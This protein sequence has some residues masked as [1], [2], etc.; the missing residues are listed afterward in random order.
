M[1]R[2]I[3]WGFIGTVDFGRHSLC[4]LWRGGSFRWQQNVAAAHWP[5]PA[6]RSLLLRVPVQYPRGFHSPGP[7]FHTG[8]TDMR[9]GCEPKGTVAG[10]R[11]WF[12]LLYP[13]ASG[14]E[15]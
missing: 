3:L 2:P 13:T 12:S 6:E 9:V 1:V 7:C 4:Q 15:P 8:I 10:L 5:F 14:G 11:G